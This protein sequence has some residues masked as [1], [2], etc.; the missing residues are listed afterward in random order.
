M[1]GLRQADDLRHA[2]KA[3]ISR[4]PSRRLR[5]Q[6]G[7]AC[8]AFNAETLFTIRHCVSLRK[9]D[10]THRNRKKVNINIYRLQYM[11]MSYLKATITERRTVMMRYKKI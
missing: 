1:S 9:I 11:E 6:K 7:S 10:S 5:L 4:V 8:L 3:Q 2:E